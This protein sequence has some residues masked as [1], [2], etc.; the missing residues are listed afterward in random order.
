MFRLIREDML[1]V[2]VGLEWRCQLL[3]NRR[4]FEWLFLYIRIKNALLT[5]ASHNKRREPNGTQCNDTK[6]NKQIRYTLRF[7][8]I[9]GMAA[10]NTAA[11]GPE[12][13]R[14]RICK[15][16]RFHQSGLTK[17]RQFLSPV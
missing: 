5:F 9:S 10:F 12:F 16:C 8:F 13:Q 2:S 17:V 7:A 3:I 4:I 15:F 1:V 14:S 6:C 11:S